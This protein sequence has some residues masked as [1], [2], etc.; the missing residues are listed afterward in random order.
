MLRYLSLIVSI[1]VLISVVF[2]KTSALPMLQ[3]VQLK[4]FDEFQKRAP[5]AY[6]DAGV[7][8]VDI[9]D[10]S[11]ARLGQ[12]PWP[13]QL[14]AQINDKLAGAGAATI[15]YDIVFAEP[16]RT[17]PHVLIPQ[18]EE[19]HGL[20]WP[21]KSL[22][23]Y[24]TM[25]ATSIKDS[26]AVTGFVMTNDSALPPA[27]KSGFAFS[28]DD[29]KAMAPTFTGAISALPDLADA[30][31]GN[32]ALNSDP[33]PDGVIRK[34]PLLIRVGNKLYPSLSAEALRVAQGASSIIV[35][36]ITGGD[37]S[38]TDVKIGEFV[39]PTDAHGRLWIYYTPYVN[40]RYLPVWKILED[41][42]DPASVQG[43]II[44]I[45]TSAAGLKD[46]RSTPLDPVSSGVEVHAQAIEQV[47]LGH[48]ISRPDWMIGAEILLML[49]LGA[50][51]IV[52]VKRVSPLIGAVVTVISITG[53]M[54]ASWHL[55]HHYGLIAE[56]VTPSLAIILVY[57]TESLFRAIRAD[58]ERKQVRNA[59]SHYMSPALV[60]QLAADPSKLK[61]G[62]EA[63]FMTIL[64]SDIRG[65]TGISEQMP[66]HDL[67]RFLNRYLTPMTGV[68][69]SHKGTIDKYIGD[70]IMAFWNAPL[71]NP[72]HAKNGC[73][74][75]LEM[76]K[77]LEAFNQSLFQP[78]SPFGNL[79]E[80]V[81]MG[82]GL[83]TGECSVGNMGSA[84]RVDYSVLGDRVNLASR[85]EGQCKEYGVPIIIGE[86]TYLAA[87]EFAA[88]ELDMIRVKGK[89]EPA[90]IFALLGDAALAQSVRF[91]TL[92]DVNQ[93]MQQAYRTQR[94]S[95]AQKVL[96][97]LE[98]QAQATNCD[99]SGFCSMMHA[100]IEALKSSALQKDWDGVFVA[101]RK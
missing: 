16:D 26:P 84:M 3:Y 94:W 89:K 93:N 51:I 23:N 33:D 59:F 80:P 18:W 29:P 9:D 68:I 11:L 22:P 19:S 14:L 78:D 60:E 77:A 42:F 65:F 21:K 97:E 92:L 37:G 87:P 39:I 12:W 6:E 79:R 90:R 45:G 49:V 44:L 1:L 85:L 100:R 31:T 4:I 47:V 57:L 75:A 83:N 50:I 17:S 34:V 54:A 32:G 55:F 56:P 46:I 43:K 71:D 30:A 10:E 67:T 40:E 41:N 82:I 76:L 20:K 36:S 64:F 74:A 38:I 72:S 58:K 81:N 63:R 98:Q 48:F 8:I 52:I 91:K 15:A 62:G 35:K 24:D 99:L 7:T 28:G 101:T 73:A 61:L 95:D 2:V 70:C 27:L 86:D 69:L 88:M 25:F 13:R 96:R 5:R 53:A 66:A